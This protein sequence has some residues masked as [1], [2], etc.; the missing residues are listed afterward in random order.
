LVTSTSSPW[1][2]RLFDQRNPMGAP[3]YVDPAEVTKLRDHPALRRLEH[4]HL[5]G[6]VTRDPEVVVLVNDDAVR[7]TARTVDEELRV[8][9]S[10]GEPLTGILIARDCALG[11]D[12]PQELAVR[13]ECK[14]TSRAR[15]RLV[16]SYRD[17]VD[18]AVGVRVD[19]LRVCLARRQR[20]EALDSGQRGA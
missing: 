14:K 16:R 11:A 4:H 18:I 2:T 19:S 17:H 20:G 5:V 10:S 7:S 12:G 9:G 13:V 15:V 3:P 8:P 6:L 1:K